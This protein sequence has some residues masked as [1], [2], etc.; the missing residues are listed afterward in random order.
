MQVPFGGS[1]YQQL[2]WFAIAEGPSSCR[3]RITAK[4]RFQEE[5]LPTL[6][7]SQGMRRVSMAGTRSMPSHVC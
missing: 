3:L 2:D 4:V 6:R 5:L 7:F 1:F